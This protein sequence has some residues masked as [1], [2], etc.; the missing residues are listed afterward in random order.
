[1]DPVVLTSLITSI[2][3]LFISIFNRVQSSKCCGPEGVDIEFGKEVTQPIS[4]I[5][6]QPK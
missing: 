2:S 4:T 6:S 3:A 1:M 5:S